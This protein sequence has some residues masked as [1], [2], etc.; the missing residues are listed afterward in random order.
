MRFSSTQSV[1]DE[2]WVAAK[3]TAPRGG[4]TD[5]EQ[6]FHQFWLN[7]EEN[8][9][10]L[11]SLTPIGFEARMT[12]ALAP[13]VAAPVPSPA[14]ATAPPPSPHT[15]PSQAP[16]APSPSSEA[17]Q[18]APPQSLSVPPARIS[19]V[20]ANAVSAPAVPTPAALSQMA[21]TP[22]PRTVV[23]LANPTSAVPQRSTLPKPAEQSSTTQP[24]QVAESASAVAA[25]TAARVAVAGESHQAVG[26]RKQTERANA[27]AGL[28]PA[29]SHSSTSSESEAEVRMN[30]PGIVALE[31]T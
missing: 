13:L 11:V 24:G 22:H 31:V 17:N 7:D 25:T 5:R 16:H 1:K 2:Q 21:N 20:P 29:D 6:R 23:P 4:T 12:R 14:A 28:E 19:T 27:A 15:V 10:D 3:V 8:E 18:P 26:N 30:S 9:E